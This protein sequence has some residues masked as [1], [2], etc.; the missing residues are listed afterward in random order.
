MSLPEW[1]LEI[2]CCGVAELVLLGQWAIYM[3]ELRWGQVIG[4]AGSAKNSSPC[5]LQRGQLL[6]STWEYKPDIFR[7]SQFL[8]KELQSWILFFFK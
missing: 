1:I 8:P 6:C 5:D 2:L 7:L 4:S 3:S